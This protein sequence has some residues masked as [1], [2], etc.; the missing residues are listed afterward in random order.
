MGGG[1]VVGNLRWIILGLVCVAIACEVGSAAA[2]TP[3]GTPRKATGGKSQA[4]SPRERLAEWDQQLASARKQADL[5]AA[6][7]K[8]LEEEIAAKKKQQAALKDSPKETSGGNA[9]IAAQAAATSAT[10]AAQRRAEAALAERLSQLGGVLWGQALANH[11]QIHTADGPSDSLALYLLAH[12]VEAGER[13]RA[14][15]AD[16]I[17]RNEQALQQARQALADTGGRRRKSAA[18]ATSLAS[19]IKQLEKEL[20][21]VRG[22]RKAALSRID[23][24]GKVRK[25]TEKEI[26]ASETRRKEP[27]KTEKRPLSK[28]EPRKTESRKAKP[29]PRSQPTAPLPAGVREGTGLDFMVAEGTQV[30]AIESGRVLFADRFKGYGNLVIL[31]HNDGTLSLYGFLNEIGVAS[32]ATVSRGQ[33]IGRSGFISDKDRA[34]LRFEMRLM[35]EGREVLINPRSWL[36]KGADLQRRLLYGTD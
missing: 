8:A 32:G 36:P 23:L 3:K 1:L 18:E 5:L 7:Q 4:A 20:D 2:A 11:V 13:E 29:T 25:S 30:H 10:L 6:R 27:T 9:A 16:S 33:V 34:G 24:L 14:E 28:S 19:E 31:E 15:I 21:K 12:D 35:K 22:D 17:Q 26:A